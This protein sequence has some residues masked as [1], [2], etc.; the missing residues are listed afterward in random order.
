MNKPII[1]V[2]VDQVLRN[3]PEEFNIQ[4]CKD[5]PKYSYGIRD[6]DCW[7]WFYEYPWKQILEDKGF[8]D[9][10]REVCI[11][12]ARQWLEF[13]SVDILLHAAPLLGVVEYLKYLVEAYKDDFDF[14][15]ITCQSN[16]FTIDITKQWLKREGLDNVEFLGV[17]VFPDK[18]LN[19]DIMID[20]SP[21]VL[22]SKPGN[23]ISIK[24]AYFYNKES[25]A[26]YVINSLTEVEEILDLIKNK[27]E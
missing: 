22:D 4:F 1:G 17:K 19:C 18:W 3:F 10:S 14:R 8:K 24:V 26:D 5:F 2:D 9:P 21:T 20:D 11:L 23:C 6:I 15:I 16:D 25:K 13:R 12:Y 7:D 27:I